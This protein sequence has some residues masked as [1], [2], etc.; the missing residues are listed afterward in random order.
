MCTGFTNIHIIY[1]LT[2]SDYNFS[3]VPSLCTASVKSQ[4]PYNAGIGSSKMVED[5]FYMF[6]RLFRRSNDLPSH[7]FVTGSTIRAR[8]AHI[9]QTRLSPNT[10]YH[11]YFRVVHKNLVMISQESHNGFCLQ[12]RFHMLLRDLSLLYIG[13]ITIPGEQ[14]WVRFQIDFIVIGYITPSYHTWNTNTDILKQCSHLK[15]RT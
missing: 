15:G 2:T 1:C 10:W 6:Y 5:C 7:V 13:T 3:S 4:P 12:Q 11:H 14:N 8:Y 9:G